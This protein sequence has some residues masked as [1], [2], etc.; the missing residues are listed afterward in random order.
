MPRFIAGRD[1]VRVEAERLTARWYAALAEY[2][3]NDTLRNYDAEQA[4]YDALINFVEENDLNY[5]ELDP[6]GPEEA[7]QP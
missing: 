1:P 7:Q 5:S 2:R 3:Q 6:R 4:A